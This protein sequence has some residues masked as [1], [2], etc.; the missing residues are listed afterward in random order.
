MRVWDA[1]NG[2]LLAEL[3]GH[4]DRVISATFSPDGQRVITASADN[5]TRTWNVSR[6]TYT[7]SQIR[8]WLDQR[9]K[10]I[11][12]TATAEECQLHFPPNTPK[13]PMECV[14]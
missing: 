12:R 13:R 11:H 3:R 2:S 8:D 14:P 10:A 4:T 6:T 5:T 1:Y 7:P 9:L